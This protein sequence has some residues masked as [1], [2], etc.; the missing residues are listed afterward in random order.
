MSLCFSK[1][2]KPKN[3]RVFSS[4]GNV[5]LFKKTKQKNAKAMINRDM[6]S[7]TIYQYINQKYTYK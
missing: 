4:L 6:R 7:I 1:F 5:A 2:N 3:D